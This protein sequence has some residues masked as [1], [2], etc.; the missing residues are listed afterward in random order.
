VTAT[1]R[2]LGGATM[3][4]RLGAFRLLTDPTLA[5]EPVAFYMDGHPSTGADHAPIHRYAPVPAIEMDG[6]DALLLSHVHSD[7]FDAA[8][9][10]RVPRDLWGL[11]PAEHVLRLEQWGF[12]VVE[13]T[14]W[15][16]EHHLERAGEILRLRVLPAHHS[17]DPATSAELGAVNGYLIE[18]ETV[19]RTL[20][21]VWTGDTVWFDDLAAAALQRGPVDVLIPHVGAVGRDGP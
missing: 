12:E 18:H 19:R 13:G 17:H 14:V 7:H 3:E 20:R 5:E 2:W 6:L 10:A 15:G 16:E 9:R 1:I 21:L 11:A 8:A 4:L